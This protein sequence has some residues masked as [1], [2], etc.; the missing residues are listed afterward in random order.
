MEAHAGGEI[1]DKTKQIT[2]SRSDKT[3]IVEIHPDDINIRYLTPNTA[4]LTDTTTIR[5][6]SEGHSRTG[7]YR[8]LRGLVKENGEWVAAGAG[9]TPLPR[10]QPSRHR[11]SRQ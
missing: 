9:L 1:V 4:I 7:I 10:Q 6:V 5:G 3:E 2:Q 8:V 11:R